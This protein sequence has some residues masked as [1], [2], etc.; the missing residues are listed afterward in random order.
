MITIDM[1]KARAIAHVHRRSARAA[2]FAPFDELIAKQIPGE[3]TVLAEA[4]R[5]EIR[6]RY[7]NV[8]SRIDVAPDAAGLRGILV[9]IGAVA[10]PAPEPPV[11][12]TLLGELTVDPL[13]VVDGGS[14]G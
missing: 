13:T 6:A 8:Q 5:Q 10:P 1:P 11:P 9:E 4:A 14:N 2:E 7:A 12:T 3:P